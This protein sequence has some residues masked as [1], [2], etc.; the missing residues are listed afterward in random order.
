M[1]EVVDECKTFFLA[2]HETTASLMTWTIMLLATY[3]DWQE[4]AREEVLRVCGS[5]EAPTYE[6]LHSL[7]VVSKCEGALHNGKSFLKIS[8]EHSV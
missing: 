4:K 8:F 6:L 5:K 3:S 1:Q 7:K 2:G